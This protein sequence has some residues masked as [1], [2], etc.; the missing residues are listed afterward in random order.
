MNE[1]WPIGNL[2]AGFPDERLSAER[3][4][5]LSFGGIPERGYFEEYAQLEEFN[6]EERLL[7]IQKFY[8]K[9]KTTFPDKRS[10][11]SFSGPPEKGYFEEFPLNDDIYANAVPEVNWAPGVPK[12]IS[13]SG[14][15]AKGYFEEFGYEA[16]DVI[17][18]TADTTTDSSTFLQTFVDNI[19]I[20]TNIE[21]VSKTDAFSQNDL[22]YLNSTFVDKGLSEKLPVKF[23]WAKATSAD[24][25]DVIAKK[26]L[27][28]KPENQYLC[29]S[30]WA[31][32]VA[33]VVG[34]VF[35]VAGLVNWMPDI[36]ATYALIN[37]PQ[38]RCKGG[39]PAELL[40][41]VASNG[42]PSKHCVDYSWC[43][44][45]KNCTTADSALHFGSDMSSLIPRHRGCYYDADHYMYKIDS[46]IR[47]IVAGS[48][49]VDVSNVQKT[50]KEHIFTNGP[51]VGGYIIFKNFTTK[52]NSGPFQGNSVFNVINGGV[53]LEKA[54]YASYNGDFGE[55]VI[56][57]LT[58]SSGNTDSDNFS[59]GHAI[60]IMGWGVQ[61]RIRVGNGPN[62]IADVPYWYCRN[63][64]GTKWGMN[65]GYFKIAMY[66]YNRKSQFSKVVEMM[67]PEGHHLRLGGVLAFT[68]SNPPTL[69]KLPANPQPPP[70]GSLSKNADFY[71]VDEDDVVTKLIDIVPPR[72]IVE[73]SQDDSQDNNWYIYALVIIFVIVIFMVVLNKNRK[74][75]GSLTE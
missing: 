30:C 61:P 27:I 69:K 10:Y 51:A 8:K 33:G 5:T 18:I 37:Y 39:D 45:N 25:P 58:F 65:G 9:L 21:F 24:S 16:S 47:S 70:P 71:R 67:T 46:N 6:E 42:L 20:N 59:G 29:G 4:Q 2:M 56:Q 40:Y 57:G 66:P 11:L 72:E 75:K 41:K 22:T 63:S 19:R 17:P 54:N 43:T 14:V 48:G 26:K 55:N 32:S 28:S 31:V 68:A 74:K 13:F 44:N 34:D 23:N 49:A 52:V 38:G 50:I 35:A 73:T 15:P 1:D 64:W 36:S 12:K 7:E 3:S 60:A 62:D 53:Y